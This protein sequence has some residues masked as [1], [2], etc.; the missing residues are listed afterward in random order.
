M[1]LRICCRERQA[2]DEFDQVL[3]TAGYTA[4]LSTDPLA[5]DPV[6][7]VQ[8]DAPAEL[9]AELLEDADDAWLEVSDPMSGTSA[10]IDPDRP[11]R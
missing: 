4:E 3:S 9:V 1:A 2:A 11:A 10:A 7:V 8:T 5:E 6:F